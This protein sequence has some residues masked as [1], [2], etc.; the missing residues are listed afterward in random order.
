M[1][2][3][4]SGFYVQ[5]SGEVFTSLV[6]FE[7]TTKRLPGPDIIR[8][9]A[10]IL[11][12]MNH[13]SS[14]Y[15][16]W[17]GIAS[18]RVFNFLGLFG[19]S[20]FFVL[21]GFLIGTILL[22]MTKYPFSWKKWGVFI[23]RRW[24][25]T[26]P[27]YY[28]WLVALIVF[29]YFFH[30]II[31]WS[32]AQEYVPYYILFMQNF[33]WEM[34]SFWYAPSWSLVVEEWFYILVPAGLIGFY[35]IGSRKEKTAL[36]VMIGLI[37]FFSCGL[38]LFPPFIAAKDV[39]SSKVAIGWF[40][41]IGYGAVMAL[42]WQS[43]RAFLVRYHK[44]LCLV[45]CGMTG[46]LWV[47]M[48]AEFSFGSARILQIGFIPMCCVGYMLCMPGAL[49]LNAVPQWLCKAA[50][51]ISNW[52][53]SLY[54]THFS[55]LFICDT[56]R[57]RYHLGVGQA[58]FLSIGMTMCFSYFIWNYIEQPILKKRPVYAWQKSKYQ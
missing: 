34:V 25:R 33:A 35:W 4:Q 18:L 23:L 43:H 9:F 44:L 58:V 39:I 3:P 52:S 40:D 42:V 16:A 36:Y 21:S 22:D 45:G 32:M 47:S 1:K 10:I 17:Y 54:L 50:L 27:A 8:S 20:L 6:A 19:V 51:F 5:K 55:V 49:L 7:Q 28:T 29:S 2:D 48:T 56:L 26:L 38:R 41:A 31:P 30:L 12:L 53:Y 46:G 15:C 37:M 11:V 24:M 13:A 14:I 57:Q